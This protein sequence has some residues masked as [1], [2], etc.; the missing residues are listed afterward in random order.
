MRVTLGLSERSESVITYVWK[1]ATGKRKMERESRAV[2][3]VSLANETNI[4]ADKVDKR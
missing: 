3:V 4:R 2:K 1:E